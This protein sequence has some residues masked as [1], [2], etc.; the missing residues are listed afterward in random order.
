M[1]S[2]SPRRIIGDD[3]RLGADAVHP[4]QVPSSRSD[5]VSNDVPASRDVKKSSKSLETVRPQSEKSGHGPTDSS[6]LDQTRRHNTN[7]E[8]DVL[9]SDRYPGEG[10]RENPFVVDWD[11]EDHENPYNW[12]KRRRWLLTAQIALGTLCVTFGSSSYAGA[13]TRARR[14]LDMTV[15]ISI[16]PISLYVV[17]F[18]VGP[19]IFAPLSEIYGRRIIFL[20]SFTTFFLFQIP[21]A[22]A[23]N[24]T[25]L[26]VFRFLAGVCGASPLANGG[27]T[28][29]D[30]WPATERGIATSLYSSGPWFGPIVGPLV[31]GFLIESGLGWRWVFWIMCIVT[32]ALSIL[33]LLFMP[34]TYAPV[35]LRRR[36]AQLNKESGGT[37]YFISRYDVG[38]NETAL[39]KLSINMRR[40]FVFLFT[41]PIV[42]LLSIYVALLYGAL[43]ATFIAFPI[44]FQG[45]RGWTPGMGGLA[46]LGIGLGVV[47]G[48]SM[49]GWNNALYIR[50]A[51]AQPGGKASPEVRLIPGMIGGVLVP[52]GLFW[53]AWTSDPSFHY[54]IP[55]A[56]G[57]PFG[58]GML[59]VFSAVV[60]YLMD[61][62]QTYTASAIGASVVLRSLLGAF[63]PLFTAGLFKKI[64]NQWGASLF[65]FLAMLC[66]PLPFLFYYFGQRVRMNSKVAR[67]FAIARMQ[68]VQALQSQQAPPRGSANV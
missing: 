12:P 51:N 66:M 36:A 24:A 56:A 30:I 52:I 1:A 13:L 68:E 48:N 3:E 37:L 47:L 64:G 21:C 43:Y 50:I 67:Q 55:I 39:Q 62:Y 4:S 46:F 5:G 41:E 27:G 45:G 9:G 53:F 16:L 10:T 22:L 63:F 19:L 61:T 18:G 58:M 54:L 7:D 8:E 65:A 29:A 14:E 17:G 15:V 20:L 6:A 57:V 25:V 40:P 44:V 38:K 34:E 11:K 32:G 59:L 33:G 23:P 60:A 35:L 2:S 49:A 28:I 42:T 26:I 31:G